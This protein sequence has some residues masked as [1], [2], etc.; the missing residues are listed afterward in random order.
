MAKKTDNKET[1]VLLDAH[2]ILH[3]A[4]H[5]LP[6]FASPSGEPTGALYG[7][8]AMLLK[9][10]EINSSVSCNKEDILVEGL[11][12]SARTIIFN[13][14]SVSLNSFRAIFNLWMKSALDSALC[15]S[16]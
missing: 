7:V 11:I 10:I 1:L 4:F 14:T 6:D 2:A 5:A 9:I 13:H 15:A 3:R 12:N 8:I 16:P